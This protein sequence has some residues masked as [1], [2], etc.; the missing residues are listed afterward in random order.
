MAQKR[1][2]EQLINAE[3]PA[4]PMIQGWIAEATNPVEVLDAPEGAG[5]CALLELQ[6]TTRS[7]MGAIVYECAGLLVDDGWLRVLGAGG[8]AR[9]ARSLPEWTRACT[10]VASGAPPPFVAVADDV[11]GGVFAVDGGALGAPGSVHYRAPD[12]LAWENLEIGYSQFLGWVLSGDLATFYREHR[13]PGWREEAAAV[14]GDRALSVVPFLWCKGPPVA[15]RS[16][17]PVP[18]SELWELSNDLSAQL[19]AAADARDAGAAA[20]AE[21]AAN[22]GVKAGL[23]AAAEQEQEEQ[24]QHEQQE[25]QELR[26]Q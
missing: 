4:W 22:A 21:E 25:Q 16:R 20:E 6:V 23:D 8:N 19:A 24:E 14:G 7:P 12:T 11:L 10:G 17:R 9:L 3:D 26:E 18:V 13:W 15:Q 2:L 5:A 1:N